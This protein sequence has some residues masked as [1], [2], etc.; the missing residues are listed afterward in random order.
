[1]VVPAIPGVRSRLEA[2]RRNKDLALGM[3]NF[4]VAQIG[5]RAYTQEDIVSVS[6]S[7]GKS[8][9]SAAPAVPTATIVVYGFHDISLTTK[10]VVTCNL[11]RDWEYL[12]NDI[13]RRFTGRVGA[14]SYDPAENTTTFLCSGESVRMFTSENAVL[15]NPD[16]NTL[17]D[18]VMSV[19]R[20]LPHSGLVNPIDVTVR[21]LDSADRAYMPKGLDFV[22]PSD[23]WEFLEKN[24]YTVTHSRS[25]EVQ[26]RSPEIRTSDMMAVFRNVRTR[27]V[28]MESITVG[29]EFEQPRSSIDNL[30]KVEYRTSKTATATADW[31]ANYYPIDQPRPGGQ[32]KKLDLTDMIYKT[33]NWKFPMRAATLDALKIGWQ[34]PKISVD[35]LALIEHEQGVW[36]FVGQCAAFSEGDPMFFGN[37]WR[38]SFKGARVIQGY[39]EKYDHES[40]DFDFSLADPALVWGHSDYHHPIDVTGM[41]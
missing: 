15:V 5:K 35:V 26:F 38:E 22:N 10:V 3:A 29:A 4:M 6:I 28:K 27:T 33:E 17:H 1:M 39:T 40:I 19:H 16:T 31:T 21:G 11:Y 30:V 7:Y 32:P 12:D 2:A 34:A 23:I 9:T 41:K 24:R 13:T 25:G 18:I 36:G 37:D 14:Q 20:S 8:G